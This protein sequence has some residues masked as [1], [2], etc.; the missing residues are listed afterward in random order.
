[1]FI[2]KLDFVPHPQP[3]ITSMKDFFGSLFVLIYTKC[4]D[5]FTVAFKA[6][7]KSPDVPRD[8]YHL[9]QAFYLAGNRAALNIE[10]GPNLTQSLLSPSVVNFCFSLELFFKSLISADTKKRATGHKLKQLFSEL[11]EN[12]QL[13]IKKQYVSTIQQPNFDSFLETISE[14]FVKVRYE[15][16]YPVEIYYEGPISVFAK[17]AYVMCSELFGQAT[18][19]PK[20]SV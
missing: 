17:I 7:G 13:L 10:V 4:M 20:V 15:Y 12:R 1:M 16:E 18:E 9:A 14:Y 8:I 5:D 6:Q 19:L 2:K 3:S 11:S